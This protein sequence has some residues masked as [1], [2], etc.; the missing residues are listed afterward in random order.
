VSAYYNDHDRFAC[1]RLK[2]MIGA[3]LIEDGVVDER[4]IED[5]RPGD[6]AGFKRC[7]FFAGVGGWA[8]ALQL[9]GWP[10]EAKCWTGSPAVGP[11]GFRPAVADARTRLLAMRRRARSSPFASNLR[12]H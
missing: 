3:G 11:H 1:E 7:H 2:N 10:D 12:A 9:A 4:P 5:V 8:F 6:L